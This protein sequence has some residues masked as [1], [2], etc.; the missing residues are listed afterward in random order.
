MK[1][2]KFGIPFLFFIFWRLFC[3]FLWIHV[4]S[5]SNCD[6]NCQ[7]PLMLWSLLATDVISIFSQYFRVVI[8]PYALCKI[9]RS[10]VS[11][12]DSV[13]RVMPLSYTSAICQTSHHLNNTKILSVNVYS[14]IAHLATINGLKITAGLVHIASRYIHVHWRVSRNCNHHDTAGC[15]MMLISRLGVKV[16]SRIKLRRHRQTRR[17]KDKCVILKHT[18]RD[19]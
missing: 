14:I 8:N 7:Q 10:H 3:L 19:R 17:E 12:I 2:I 11:I 6:D 5:L 16:K 1:V 4:V 18:R 13:Q 9:S 15:I